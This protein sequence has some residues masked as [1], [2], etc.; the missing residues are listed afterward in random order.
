MTGKSR[1]RANFTR[2]GWLGI[3]TIFPGYCGLRSNRRL[4]ARVARSVA[5]RVCSQSALSVMKKRPMV[6]RRAGTT[7]VANIQRQA[8]R[9]GTT[10]STR[11]QPRCHPKRLLPGMRTR[12]SAEH[13]S[14]SSPFS[15]PESSALLSR[16]GFTG[17]VSHIPVSRVNNRDSRWTARPQ[18]KSLVTDEQHC[19]NIC[20]CENPPRDFRKC[21]KRMRAKYAAEQ[22]LAPHYRPRSTSAGSCGSLHWCLS[23]RLRSH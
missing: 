20:I 23:C 9:F 6:T 18:Q 7:A 3:R 14:C 17:F 4:A 1:P 16:R 19:L 2:A 22:S 5:P 11:S 15:P 10:T 12:T 13:P 21:C 8:L